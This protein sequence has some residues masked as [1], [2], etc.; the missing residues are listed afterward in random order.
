[1]KAWFL[2][3]PLHGDTRTLPDEKRIRQF[4]VQ[5]ETWDA[6]KPRP[7]LTYVRVTHDDYESPEGTEPFVWE[8]WL[9][10]DRVSR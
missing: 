2:G 5:P 4:L 7:R 9:Q 3:G 6:A 10:E 8:T 1:M